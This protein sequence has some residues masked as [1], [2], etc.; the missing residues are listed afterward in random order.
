MS[1]KESLDSFVINL[2]E[3]DFIEVPNPKRQVLGHGELDWLSNKQY[4][5]WRCSDCGRFS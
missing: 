3:S 1:E 4:Y 2:S 5:E